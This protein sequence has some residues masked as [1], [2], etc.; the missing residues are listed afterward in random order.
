MTFCDNVTP[1]KVWMMIDFQEAQR[2]DRTVSAQK[3]ASEDAI[4][5]GIYEGSHKGP[6]SKSD[7]GLGS[8]QQ[9]MYVGQL[10]FPRLSY[11]PWFPREV[12]QF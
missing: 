12:L 4:V 8:P 6:L 5:T 3:A 1:E 10:C 9:D 11:I 7:L 2:R